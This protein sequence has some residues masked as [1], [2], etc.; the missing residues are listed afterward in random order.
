MASVYILFSVKLNKY[1]IG[2]CND[3][4]ARI[5]EHKQKKFQGAYT[6]ISDDWELY[7]S[8]NDLE[9]KQA[10]AIESHI[11]RMKSKVYIENLLKYPTII[12]RLCEEY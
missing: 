6:K 2:S 8:I 12:E 9:Y 7:L 5:E 1:Y 3:L 4:V 11:K 10:R